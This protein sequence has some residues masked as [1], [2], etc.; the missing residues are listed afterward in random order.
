M[1]NFT[2]VALGPCIR[3][4]TLSVVPEHALA[5]KASRPQAQ[6]Q[7]TPGGPGLPLFELCYFWLFIPNK[8]AFSKT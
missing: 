1:L 8:A 7:W 6:A 4:A 2:P 3:L 5:L